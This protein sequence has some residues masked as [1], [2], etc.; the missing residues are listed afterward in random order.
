MLAT[1]VGHTEVSRVGGQRVT[2]CSTALFQP[3]P[4]EPYVQLVAAYGS[5]GL[6]RCRPAWLRLA[7]DTRTVIGPFVDVVVATSAHRHRLPPHGDHQLLP[8]FFALADVAQTP[9]VMHLDGDARLDRFAGQRR[10]PPSRN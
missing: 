7:P 10:T 4:S 1:F 3:P 5:P 9:Q 2:V 6:I 8:G